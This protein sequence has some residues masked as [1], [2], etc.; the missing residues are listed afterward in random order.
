MGLIRTIQWSAPWSAIWPRSFNRITDRVPNGQRLLQASSVKWIIVWYLPS[1]LA[2]R[3]K[4][5]NNV[6]YM[7]VN[8]NVSMLTFIYSQPPT[9]PPPNI[10]QSKEHLIKG[11]NLY[12]IPL[13]PLQHR[14]YKKNPQWIIL[15]V[16]MEY[17]GIGKSFPIGV[18]T[19]LI[20][21]IFGS[22]IQ[23]PHQKPNLLQTPEI[24]KRKKSRK[25]KNAKNQDYCPKADLVPIS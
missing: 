23:S 5:V 9:Q 11:T 3:Y 8:L 17:R 22:N 7:H 4:V 13:I 25:K 2:I 20:R 16:C 19:P 12:Q 10:K 1:F 24:P 21:S 18:W 6:P 15:L 14:N